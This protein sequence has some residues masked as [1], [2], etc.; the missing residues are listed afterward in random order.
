MAALALTGLD[1]FPWRME[2]AEELQRLDIHHTHTLEACEKKFGRDY[3]R[4]LVNR[5]RPTE[6][7]RPLALVRPFR[8]HVPVNDI[9]ERNAEPCLEL[10][11]TSHFHIDLYGNYLPGLCSGLSIHIDD[12]GKPVSSGKYP[13]LSALYARG[14]QGLYHRAVQTC[15]FQARPEGYISKCDLCFHIRKYLVTEQF[16]SSPDFQPAGYYTFS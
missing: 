10:D 8:R 15:A 3:I 14:I 9:L 5:Y 13:F 16:V 2:F 7:G 11:S 12:L 1:I 6:R 4:D